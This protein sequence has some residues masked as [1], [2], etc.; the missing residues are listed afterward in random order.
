[1]EN[2]IRLKKVASS[3]E[4]TVS[5][6]AHSIAGETRRGRREVFSQLL[7]SDLNRVRITTSDFVAGI[8]QLKISFNNKTVY[9]QKLVVVR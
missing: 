5:R 7:Y 1:M 9:H 6:I 2:S 4:T 8:Y 3:F